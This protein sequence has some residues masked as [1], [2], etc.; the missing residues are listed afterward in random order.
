M[1]AVIDYG[2]GNIF[3]VMN[4]LDKLCANAE[5]V[6][7]PKKIKEANAIIIPGVGSFNKTIQNL[8]AY[9]KEIIDA[10]E[11]GMPFLGICMGLQ[12]LFEKSEEGVMDGFNIIK[13]RVVRLPNNVTVPQMG[14][15]ELKIKK[16][17]RLLSGIE[18]GDFFYFVHSYHCI[19]EDKKIIAATT[20][21]GTDVTA[22]IEKENIAAVQFHP[23]KSGEKG[24]LILENFL[25]ETKC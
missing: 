24:L 15:N 3:S 9:K 17:T 19:P 21:Y 6:R 4:A 1:I 10:I 16:N 20:E 7:D 22:A 18:E 13:G 2:M 8:T 25:R 12:V 23:E 11:S 5:I 14:W